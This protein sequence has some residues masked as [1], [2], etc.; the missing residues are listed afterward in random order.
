VREQR[1]S[2]RAALPRRQSNGAQEPISYHVWQRYRYAYSA[3]VYD[4][5]HRLKVIPPPA[6]MDQRLVRHELEVTGSVGA[7]DVQWGVDRF[8][9]QVCMVEVDRVESHLEFIAQYEVTRVHPYPPNGREG[10]S[11]LE[12]YLALTALTTPDEA[13]REVASR[14]ARETDDPRLQAELAFHWSSESIE[15]RTGATT[16]STP[17]A[18][19]RQLGYGVCQDYAHIMLAVLRLLGIPARYVS[20]HLL[21]EGAPHAWVQALHADA[22]SGDRTV[23]YD[24]THKRLAGLDYITVALGRDFADIS[25]TSGHFRGRATGELTHAKR[26]RIAPDELS[27]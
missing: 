17:A 14:I 8:G 19:A 26:A 23:D 18:D 22:E 15:Y 20:G 16:W 25:P 24:P 13:M 7:V 3:P 11:D 2:D 10:F 1:P 4:I 27:R 9:N 21:G 12:P 5:R 6:H